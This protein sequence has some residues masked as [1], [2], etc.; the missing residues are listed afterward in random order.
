MIGVCSNSSTI[1]TRLVK[2]LAM[3]E[4][5]DKKALFSI[6]TSINRGGYRR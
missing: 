3:V 2:S 1:K 6:V 5:C 4:V